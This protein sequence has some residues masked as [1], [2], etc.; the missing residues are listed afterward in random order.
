MINQMKSG[1]WFY[2]KWLMMGAICYALSTTASARPNLLD[3]LNGN[4]PVLSSGI[5]PSKLLTA[6][7]AFLPIAQVVDAQTLRLSWTINSDYYLYQ[8]KL[9]LSLSTA[10]SATDLAVVKIDFPEGVRY[11]DAFFGDQIIYDQNV[12]MDAQLTGAWPQSGEALLTIKAQGC[13]KIGLCFPPEVWEMPVFLT[14]TSPAVMQADE[15]QSTPTE[16]QP[17][18]EVPLSSQNVMQQQLISL[19]F[20]A[21]PFI[22][23]IGLLLAFNPCTYPLLPILAG[24][25]VGQRQMSVRRGLGLSCLYVLGIGL[26][27]VLIA[28]SFVWLGSGLQGYFQHPIVLGA[29]ALLFVVLALSMFGLYQIQLPARMQQKLIG[30]SNQ[31]TAGSGKGVLVMGALSALIASPCATPPLAAITTVLAQTGQFTLAASA[32]FVLGVGMGMPLI[33]AGAAAGHYLP[34]AG[35]W[36]NDIKT[37]FVF[38]LLS[39]ALYVLE[40][41]VLPTHALLLWSVWSFV[42]GLWALWLTPFAARGMA[43]LPKIMGA[44]ALVWAILLLIGVALGHTNPRLPLQADPNAVGWINQGQSEQSTARKTA[45]FIAIKTV[46]DLDRALLAHRGSAILLDFYASWCLPCVNLERTVFTDAGVQQTW[47][48]MVRLQADVT[49]NDAS[50]R[51]LM[52]RFTLIGPPAII[53]FDHAGKERRDFRV[54]EGNF[55]ADVFAAHLRAFKSALTDAR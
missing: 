16:L 1:F 8:S 25:I 53:L 18:V 35:A 47:Q 4:Q 37:F 13:A 22:F 49:A 27:Y 33:I 29:F 23:I 55:A 2:A 40:R 12:T 54:N 26:V 46:E 30:L 28:L 20:V 45:T 14:Q 11:H 21:L 44:V 32:A 41:L 15:A 43:L 50:D 24:L 42:I 31:Q 51:A 36:M 7:Q 48:D 3:Q 34:Q 6:Q 10:G 52:A 17:V 19:G 5:D 39:V 38:L 9:S